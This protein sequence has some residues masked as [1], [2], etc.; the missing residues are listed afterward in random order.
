MITTNGNQHESIKFGN[1]AKQAKI[2]IIGKIG[3]GR[4][5]GPLSPVDQTQTGKILGMMVS[6]PDSVCQST[7]PEPEMCSGS[8]SVGRTRASV[9]RN[10]FPILPNLSKRRAKLFPIATG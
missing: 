1:Q 3:A 4:S 10:L 7:G 2:D 8:R 5:T 9:D 6:R